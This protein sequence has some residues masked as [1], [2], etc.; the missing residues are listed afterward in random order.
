MIAIARARKKSDVRNQANFY[1]CCYR[2]RKTSSFII[3]SS[4]IH[5]IIHHS[6]FISFNSPSSVIYHCDNM[7]PFQRAS[8]LKQ[9]NHCECKQNCFDQFSVQEIASQIVSAQ[10]CTSR[11]ELTRFLST[12]LPH[13]AHTTMICQHQYYIQSKPVCMAAFCEMNGVSHNKLHS[14][15]DLL[16]REAHEY[17]NSIVIPSSTT[18]VARQYHPH[19]HEKQ[20]E[21]IAWISNWIEQH[22]VQSDEKHI[23]LLDNFTWSEVYYNELRP[24]WSQ[25]NPSVPPPCLSLYF[26]AK[27]A[28]LKL[29]NVAFLRPQDH[30]VCSVCVEVEEKLKNEQISDAVNMYAMNI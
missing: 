12:L 20:T 14:V 30:P 13:D 24:S 9:Y 18:Q 28:A 29:N 22:K 11:S 15:H 8:H 10:A 19:P 21:T 1:H 4:I 5:S 23:Y 25:S 27:D 17:I 26:R 7:D 6:S 2:T 16:K 3:R